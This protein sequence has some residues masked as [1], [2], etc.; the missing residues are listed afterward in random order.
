M[1]LLTTHLAASSSTDKLMAELADRVLNHF[2]DVQQRRVKRFDVA[3]TEL[4]FDYQDIQEGRVADIIERARNPYKLIIN[5]LDNMF[6]KYT[7]EDEVLPKEPLI[8]LKGAE[9]QDVPAKYGNT[10]Y[11]KILKGYS[12]LVAPIEVL[13]LFV[14]TKHI[15]DETIGEQRITK[16]ELQGVIDTNVTKMYVQKMEERL[17]EL[18]E[19]P[20]FKAH[21][22]SMKLKATSLTLDNVLAILKSALYKP[23]FAEIRIL[24]R[25]INVNVILIGRKT[26]KFPDGL[27]EVIHVQ[28]PHYLFMIHSFDRKDGVDRYQLVVKDK[29]KVILGKNDLPAELLE[30]ID[31]YLEKTR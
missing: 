14:K 13:D 2:F 8:D 31:A 16:T 20:S 5:K 25:A 10:H 18:Y 28:S 15:S 30:M 11:R 27:F 24:A 3:P 29:E 1:Q 17:S 9:F 23:S 12:V 26:L 19:N 4:L 7:F 22:K 6:D 21:V